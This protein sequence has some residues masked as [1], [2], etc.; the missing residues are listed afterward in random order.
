[1]TSSEIMNNET[2]QAILE[3]F[4]TGIAS[5]N[6]Y[7]GSSYQLYLDTDD[8]SLIINQEASDDTWIQR[9]DGSLKL[10]WRISGY[11]D[12]PKEERYTEGR[13]L[14]D[15]GYQEWLEQVEQEISEVT[16]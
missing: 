12:I 10:I 13:D 11:C 1:M 5:C 15:Y 4:F 3:E 8:D 2:N 9:D 14:L 7:D 16:A 6:Y